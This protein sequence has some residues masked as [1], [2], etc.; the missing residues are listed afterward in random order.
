MCTIFFNNQNLN[1]CSLYLP[2]HTQITLENFN[3]LL[4][5][6]PN[7][8]I[9]LG[10]FNAKH[11]SWGATINDTRGN[12]I[13]NCLLTND[14]MV[15]NGGS[16]TR[17]EARRDLYSHID[18]SCCSISLSDKLN[19]NVL[20]STHNSDHFPITIKFNFDMHYTYHQQYKIQIR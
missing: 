18:V 8:K 17:Y 13:T 10:D 7:P 1:I 9:I 2:D 15:L 19:W 4:N 3:A 11:T 20:D 16:P 5:K 14:L 6:I 12:I